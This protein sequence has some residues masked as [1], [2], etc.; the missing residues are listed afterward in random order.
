MSTPN[1]QWTVAFLYSRRS[2]CRGLYAL[3]ELRDELPLVNAHFLMP[4][5]QVPK[6]RDNAN[7]AATGFIQ[8][9]PPVTMA[10]IRYSC[11][12]IIPR[13]ANGR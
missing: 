3:Y 9:A 11:L 8:R 12:T 7:G 13:R 10:N 1:Q 4:G 2:F 5:A 6:R